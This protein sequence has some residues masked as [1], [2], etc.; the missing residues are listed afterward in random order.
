MTTPPA[1]P[2][3]Q[4]WNVPN[5]LTMVRI[6]L[7]P[8]FI[9]SMLA[10]GTQHGGLRWVAFVLFAVA[11]YT[12]QLDGSIARKR[13]LITDFGKIADPIADKLLTGSALVLLSVLG[14]LPWWITILILVREWGITALRFVVIRYGVMP[15]SPG[16]KLKTVLQTVAILLYLFPLTPG[17]P[18]LAA[19]AFWIMILALAV[20]VVTGIDYIAKAVRLRATALKGRHP[21]GR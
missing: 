4:L 18:I 15:A 2:S 13:N 9:W 10:D 8:F 3:S 19:I 21:E 7:V 12:D 11:I 5:I 14:E 16:G 6:V 17:T 1:A 20:T